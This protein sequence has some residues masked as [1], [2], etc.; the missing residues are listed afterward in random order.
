MSLLIT[1]FLLVLL[2]K[3]IRWVEKP[4]FNL[5]SW[6]VPLGDDIL[7]DTL[8][9]RWTQ[10]TAIYFRTFDA[11]ASKTL[12]D[13]RKSILEYQKKLAQTSSQDEFAKWAKLRR[14]LDKGISD[15]GKLSE[16]VVSASVPPL[17]LY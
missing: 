11:N 2:I 15:L 16:F 6:E 5:V 17:L 3:A 12:Q 9:P 14:K 8:N 13:L 10:A 1:I 4:L 7:T